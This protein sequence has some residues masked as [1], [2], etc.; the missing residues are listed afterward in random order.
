MDRVIGADA[1]IVENEQGMR[2]VDVMTT[3]IETARPV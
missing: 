3:E 1:P 2:V